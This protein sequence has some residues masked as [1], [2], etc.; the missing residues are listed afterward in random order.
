MY[1]ELKYVKILH[2]TPAYTHNWLNLREHSLFMIK[3]IIICVWMCSHVANSEWNGETFAFFECIRLSVISGLPGS[4]A[5][6]MSELRR[7][8]NIWSSELQGIARFKSIFYAS[9]SLYNIERIFRD[10]K[11]I[12]RKLFITRLQQS[13][14]NHTI[15]I[16][17]SI[18][19]HFISQ[20]L[21]QMRGRTKTMNKE[22]YSSSCK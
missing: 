20:R 13:I 18:C 22:S 2:F 8:W 4:W 21:Q 11:R 14:A 10:L 19:F 16:Q 7:V 12:F 3:S 1:N 5:H 15:N 9:E 17:K 6:T